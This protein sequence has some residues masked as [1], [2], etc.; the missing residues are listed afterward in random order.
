MFFFSLHHSK[1]CT[2]VADRVALIS[3]FI[4]DSYCSQAAN[5]TQGN[6][7]TYGTDKQNTIPLSVL[8]NGCSVPLEFCMHWRMLKI[9]CEPSVLLTAGLKQSRLIAGWGS[10]TEGSQKGSLQSELQRSA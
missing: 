6:F 8:W 10:L 9:R 2:T 1:T 5:S 3:F 4:R 7:N